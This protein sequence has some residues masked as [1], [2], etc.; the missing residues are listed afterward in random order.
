MF[1]ADTDRDWE[2]W[3][4]EDPYFGVCTSNKYHK[5]NLDEGAIANFFRSGETHLALVL[6]TIRQHLDPGFSPTS[7][8]DFGCGVGRVVMPL[9]RICKDVVGL[10]VSDSMLVE[11]RRNCELR[12][13]ANVT[14]VHGDDQLSGINTTFDF[15]HS[16]LVFQHIPTRRGEVILGR[17]LV[18]LR[19]NGIGALHFTFGSTKRPLFSRFRTYLYQSFQPVNGL[20]NMLK[21]QPFKMP[22]MQMNAYDMNKILERLEA[23]GCSTCYIRFTEKGSRPGAFIFFRKN[24]AE[25]MP[26]TSGKDSYLSG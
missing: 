4:K 13:I 1:S 12:G 3:G 11:A 20:R 2:Y 22:F 8:L 6:E 7:A 26:Q 16:Y 14:F 24:P 18:L 5:E 17:M 21:R 19:E 15:V 25:K 10:D 9:A 23:S